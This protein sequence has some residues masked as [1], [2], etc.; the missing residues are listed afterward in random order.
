MR[1]NPEPIFGF[2]VMYRGL[3]LRYSRLY[4]RGSTKTTNITVQNI[5]QHP[6]FEVQYTIQY[7]IKLLRWALNE[8]LWNTK[9][10]KKKK[11]LLWYC[12]NNLRQETD[13]VQRETIQNYISIR[14]SFV[15]VVSNCNGSIID[16]IRRVERYLLFRV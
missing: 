3:V 8:W 16:V 13:R 7:F 9:L 5:S 10:K 12:A 6:V 4:K 1:I 2:I 15:V 11:S 14:C